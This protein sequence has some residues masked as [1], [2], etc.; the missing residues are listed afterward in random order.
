MNSSTR[1]LVFG[2]A[3]LAILWLPAGSHASLL[4]SDTEETGSLLPLPKEYLVGDLRDRVLGPFDPFWWSDLSSK[5]GKK[6]N[7]NKQ[8]ERWQP[9]RLV[10]SRWTELHGRDSFAESRSGTDTGSSGGGGGGS[11]NG[12]ADR[13]FSSL[14]TTTNQWLSY[15]SSTTVPDGSNGGSGKTADVA[16]PLPPSVLLFGSGLA[17][18]IAVGRKRPLRANC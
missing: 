10:M 15:D 7:G 14:T 18:L 3:I 11:R 17:G 13:T 6:T 8:F 1:L 5:L 2:V 9:V 12:H 4:D 16:T